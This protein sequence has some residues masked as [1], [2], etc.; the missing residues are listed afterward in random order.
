MVFMISQPMAGLSEQEILAERNR[1]TE[2]LVSQGH[3]VIDT[4]FSD[5][6]KRCE[7]EH[8]NNCP[9]YWLGKAFEQMSKCDAVYFVRGWACTRGC[10]IEYSAACEYGLAIVNEDV[11]DK[12]QG[13]A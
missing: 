2:V 8:P 12:C 5:Y 4:Y 7:T 1:V 3:E 13:D 9:L 11:T 6:Q 10:R